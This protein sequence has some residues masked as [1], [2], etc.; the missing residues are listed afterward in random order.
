MRVLCYTAFRIMM[1]V[2]QAAFYL[3]SAEMEKKLKLNILL[4]ENP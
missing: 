3:V 4:K 1:V 2:T